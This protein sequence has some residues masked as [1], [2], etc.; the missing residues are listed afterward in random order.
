MNRERILVV[1]DDR[2]VSRLLEEILLNDY[3]VAATEKG[4]E[5][6]RILQEESFSL[7]IVDLRLPDIDGMEV[8]RQAK[9]IRPST[10]SLILT[11]YGTIEGAVEAMKLGVYNYLTKPFSRDQLLFN[12][13]KAIEHH[14]LIKENEGLREAIRESYSFENIIG[15]S[16]SM[17]EVFETIRKVADTDAT[18]LITGES[19]TGK[20]LIAK[21]IHYN[22]SRRRFPFIPL[23][24]GAIPHDLLES[25][26]FG[27]E[28]GAFTGAVSTRQG[29]FERA[30]RGTIFLDEIGEL[31]LHLQVKLLRVLQEKEFER[32]GGN[33]TIKVDVRIIAA[34][35][36]N[37]EEAIEN[38][39]FREDLYYRLNVIP[40]YVPPLRERKGDIPLL[41]NH[42]LKKLSK[43]KRKNIIGVSKEAMEMLMNYNWPGN[44]RELENIIE[45]TVILKEDEGL[46]TPEDLPAK[47]R[48]TRNTGVFYF[49]IPKDG[50]DLPAL[51]EELETRFI[52]KALDRAG[53]VKSKAAQLLGINRTTLIE[54]MRKRG[55]LSQKEPV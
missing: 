48:N 5:A 2:D 55:M 13:K 6:L 26:L 41:V 28:K 7:M 16:Q 22:S 17:L 47:I 24:C 8:I 20:E 31:P 3:E 37:L 23:N 34:T 42:F 18:V 39:T 36:R 33:R 11:G 46:I 4:A 21:A 32:V 52:K 10:A 35:N 53:G 50:I 29:R 27:H 45:R 44:I 15:K 40:I 1:E 19:G 38:K 49:D 54:K 30:D 51:L 25:E 14:H 12:V 9:K 43:T